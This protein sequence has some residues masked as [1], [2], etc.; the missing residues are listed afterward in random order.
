[1]V[2]LKH[3]HRKYFSVTVYTAHWQ[4]ISSKIK[5]LC[6]NKQT[7]FDDFMIKKSF[8]QDKKIKL[9]IKHVAIKYFLLIFYIFYLKY[10]YI[11]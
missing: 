11:I 9:Q 6:I 3:S 5:F 4:A 10:Y 8:F 1:M 2:V 7:I